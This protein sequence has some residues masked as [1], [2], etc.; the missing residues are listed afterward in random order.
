ML[1]K[2]V[3]LLS[4]DK[5]CSH[6]TNDSNAMVE[7]IAAEQILPLT[8]TELKDA[9]DQSFKAG[10]LV[11]AELFYKRSL[12]IDSNQPAANNNRGIVL[13]YL[14]RFEEALASYERAIALKPDNT[15]AYNNQ[16]I[17]LNDMHRPEE[18]LASYDR[19]ITLKPDYAE[20]Y[21]NRGIALNNLQRLDEAL[22]SYDSAIALKPDYAEAYY[23]RGLLLNNLKRLDE[24]LTDYDHA[25][26][27]RPEHAEA[28]NNR[29]VILNDLKRFEEAL[30]SYDRALVLRPDHAET[31]NNLG[32]AL[33][34][35]K[36]LDDALI[37]YDRAIEL[38]PDYAEAYNNRGLVFYDLKRRDKALASYNQAISL[39]PDYAE[40]YYNRG[41][42][43][44]DLKLM[45]EALASYDRA[46]E[47]NPEYAD[48][49]HNRGII[50]NDLNR[51][52]EALASY[53]RA[54][55]L[56]PDQ[57]FLYGY[58]LHNHMQLCY[59]SNY[60]NKMMLL[61]NK[62]E[63]DEKA[64][65]P[66][67]LLAQSH[68]RT[69]QRKV[70]EI[71]VQSRYPA[72]DALPPL[73]KH[74]KH[75]KIRIGYFSA[76][77]RNHPVSFLT[78][79][80]FEVHDRSR[81]ELIAFYFGP[82]T[83]DE[84]KTRVAAAFDQFIDVRQ[85]SD[86]EIALMARN[87]EIDIAIDLG[88]FTAL[89]RTGIF[90]S[91]A[92][93]LQVSYLG[94]LGTMGADYMD[95]LIADATIVPQQHQKDY[96]EKIIYLPSYQVND[97]KRIIADKVFTREE[98]GLPS[99]GFVFC[100]LNN[101]YKITPNIFDMW[102]RILH[103]VA[104]SVL[105]LLSVDKAVEN[106]LRVEAS[107]RGIDAKRLIF[108]K[109]LP[110][111]EYLAR[112]RA[113]DLFLDTSPYNAGTTASDALWAGLPVL[114]YLGETFA[115]RM[116]ASLLNAIH[117]PELITATPQEY[118]TQA[119]ALATQPEKL[120][121]IK[122]KLANNRLTT[123]LFDTQQFSNHIEAAYTQIYQR[124]QADLMPDHIHVKANHHE[125]M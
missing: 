60:D 2:L 91:R 42:T 14:N 79:E 102:M 36:R 15:Q 113:A 30:A 81:F 44:N 99:T 25:I 80:L 125:Q 83:E 57:E 59:W 46:V 90:A 65:V 97:T 73:S 115:G 21:Y 17:V 7:A 1:K 96:T 5:S 107:R 106:N 66:F 24:A 51:L 48:A 101:N 23:N 76:D 43:L 50:L 82:D 116:A 74:P 26:A 114:T 53:D 93:P 88:G 6:K 58:W 86:Q 67:V 40:A 38:K 85:L 71:F 45:N 13:Y 98:L 37:S 20:A 105:W 78:A 33:S 100:C 120:M 84:M 35:L 32:T 34:N 110:L 111:P 70:A 54:I 61:S 77:F 63:R 89:S 68:S 95:Y 22:A 28:F 8:A 92:A 94:Y 18:A 56:M 72:N 11:Q 31:Y 9:G 104:H 119:I 69:L 124:Y 55:T 121:K 109:H 52:D 122:Q 75:N 49:Y 19:A 103:Q 62:I 3:R 41:V 64:S 117:L 10:D 12:E 29:G 39:K 118:E 4:K 123:P 87:L 112:Y 16:G 108:A 27:L 47:L